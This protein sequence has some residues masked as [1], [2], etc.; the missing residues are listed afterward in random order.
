MLDLST[1]RLFFPVHLSCR[2]CCR[3]VNGTGLCEPEIGAADLVDGTWC[4]QGYCRKSK[5][6]NE[7]ADYVTRH[8]NVLTDRS[9]I[10]PII[11]S[12]IVAIIVLLSIAIYIPIGCCIRRADNQELL[13]TRRAGRV[14]TVDVARPV[15]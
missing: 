6:V 4:A 2:R 14:R 8:L 15:E 12:N 7:A 10:W 1:L 5:C 9:R 11:Q 13:T 3:D